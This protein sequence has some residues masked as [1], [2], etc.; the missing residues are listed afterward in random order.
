MSSFCETPLGYKI[1]CAHSGDP[2]GQLALCLHGLGG[3]IDTYTPL[4]PSL[5]PSLHV[6]RVDF[7]G[8][9]QS[10]LPV[11]PTRI[12]V[13]DHVA[14]LHHL[15]ASLQAAAPAA[16]PQQQQ[17]QQ[18]QPPSAPVLLL[19]HSLGGIVALQYAAQHPDAVAGLF[20]LGP[21]RATSHIPA[22]RDAMRNTAAN[23][24]QHG[25]ATAAANAAKTNFYVDTPERTVDPTL[26]QAVS[27]AVAASDPEGYAQTCEALVDAA[28]ADPDYAAIRCPAVFVAGDKD[29]ISPVSRSQ[30]LAALVRGWT[31]V[32]VVR[33]GHQ[34]IL[35]DL[36]GV[37]KA[38]QLFLE[39]AT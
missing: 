16:D 32:E 18:Q 4:L 11:A 21:G 31:A 19:G 2:S 13:A 5:P 20:L 22:V 3:S 28:H 14:N 17:Q 29:G 37:K 27:D 1:H 39:K 9:G 26:R 34:P 8:F 7:P 36:G 33:S 35:E 15:I 38:L 12:S 25:I 23:V 24:R 30:D 10:P 6:V